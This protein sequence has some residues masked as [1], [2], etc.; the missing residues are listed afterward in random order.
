MITATLCWNRA[1]QPEYP[2][3]HVIEQDADLRLELWG[4]D[5]NNPERRVL[6][7][8]SDS[9][10]DNVEHIYFTCDPNY[11]TYAIRVQ[12]N[13]EQ[14]A[15]A[16]AEQRF[17]LAWSI[18]PDRQIGDPWWDDLNADNQ[19]DEMDKLIYFMI[20]NSAIMKID[21]TS[22]E[23]ALKVSPAR[24]QLLTDNWPVW[25]HYLTDWNE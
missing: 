17:A 18:G 10:N 4:I 6:L 3:N 1:Y 23:E 13:E 22:L 11:T 20:E 21:Q 9:V 12:F 24:I 5:P 14:P 15:D 7:D 25:K 2:F 19:I 8:Y 16:S